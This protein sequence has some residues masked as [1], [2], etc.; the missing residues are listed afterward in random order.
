MQK[1][2]Q[3]MAKQLEMLQK[4]SKEK[5]DIFGSYDAV[6]L[7]NSRLKAE[8]LELRSKDLPTHQTVNAVVKSPQNK[9]ILSF[10]PFV[11]VNNRV[12]DNL[13][14]RCFSPSH[15]YYHAFV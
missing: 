4:S 8:L 1:S 6:L 11:S 15:P 5:A 2:V 10:F 3:D 13:F 12:Q 14:E 9:P 7:E